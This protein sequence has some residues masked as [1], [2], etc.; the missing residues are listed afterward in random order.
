MTTLEQMRLCNKCINVKLHPEQET[1]CSLTQKAPDFEGEC[2]NFELDESVE[3]EVE[4]EE[5]IKGDEVILELNDDD[6]NKLKDHQNFNFALIGGL[7]AT[8]I[9][10]ILWAII[11]VAT[12]YQIGYMA[13]GVL[14]HF[15]T[16]FGYTFIWR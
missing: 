11:S 6:M 9:S 15:S 2:E 13:I 16:I 4:D 12:Q 3:E 1:I 8:L 5:V 10:A 7:V 14:R